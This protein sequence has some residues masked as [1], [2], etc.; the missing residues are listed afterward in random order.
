MTAY[1]LNDGDKVQFGVA[2]SPSVPP[3]FVFQYYKA[4]KVKQTR[5]HP[6]DEPDSALPQVKRSKTKEAQV[7]STGPAN[8]IMVRGIFCPSE[9]AEFWP[10]SQLKIAKKFSFFP[11]YHVCFPQLRKVKKKNIFFTLF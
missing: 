1:D 6:A 9:G 10:H 4:L 11:Q 8:L 2:T 5:K 7:R 3:E